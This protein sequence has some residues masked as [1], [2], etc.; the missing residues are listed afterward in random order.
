MKRN[1][2]GA[3]KNALTR[4]PSPFGSTLNTQDNALSLGSGPLEAVKK[5]YDADIKILKEISVLTDAQTA[6]KAALTEKVNSFEKTLAKFGF[7][8]AGLQA[9]SAIGSLFQVAGIIGAFLPVRFSCL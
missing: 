9:L 3:Q 7:A 2:H 8:K 5:Y 1:E 4:T 6:E